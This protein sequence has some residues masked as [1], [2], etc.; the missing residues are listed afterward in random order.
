MIPQQDQHHGWSSNIVEVPLL[1]PPDVKNSFHSTT[2]T[3]FVAAGQA[4]NEVV[5]LTDSF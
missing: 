2:K 1:V 3:E 4:S 5:W